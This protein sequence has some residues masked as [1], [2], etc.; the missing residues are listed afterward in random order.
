MLI[1]QGLKLVVALRPEATK[2]SAGPPEQS[3]SP[4]KAGICLKKS[5]HGKIME[6]TGTLRFCALHN[7]FCNFK[8]GQSRK[9]L[10]T[11]L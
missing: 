1:T 10:M 6:L 9:A 8:L 3:H 4:E 11:T 2:Y 5:M 7:L